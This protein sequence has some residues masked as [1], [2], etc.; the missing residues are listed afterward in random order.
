[1]TATTVACMHKLI[2]AC[3]IK[4]GALAPT[5]ELKNSYVCT[6]ESMRHPLEAQAYSRYAEPV[7]IIHNSSFPDDLALPLAGVTFL[8][9]AHPMAFRRSVK[10][11]CE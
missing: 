1:M 3:R 9:P 7:T 6:T 11:G 2:Y 8:P 10:M 5:N 4:D